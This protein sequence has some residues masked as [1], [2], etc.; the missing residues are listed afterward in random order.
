VSKSNGLVRDLGIGPGRAYL[1]EI[2][3]AHYIVFCGASGEEW[4]GCQSSPSAEWG[5]IVVSARQ[6]R[7][8]VVAWLRARG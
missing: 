5:Q 7:E 2:N 3:G 6:T 1:Y 4:D 8:D